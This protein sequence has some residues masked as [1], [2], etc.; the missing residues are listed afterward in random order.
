[1][2]ISNVCIMKSGQGSPRKLQPLS[3]TRR[4]WRTSTTSM[5][6]AQH[7]VQDHSQQR[8][9]RPNTL[10]FITLPRLPQS[11]QRLRKFPHHPSRLAGLCHRLLSAL[12]RIGL[13][14]PCLS[15]KSIKNQMDLLAPPYTHT[16]LTVAMAEDR[17]IYESKQLPP[18]LHKRAI[19]YRIR[20][21]ILP[22][23][24][25]HRTSRTSRY[26][27]PMHPNCFP[28]ERPHRSFLQHTQATIPHY[29]MPIKVPRMIILSKA[30]ML[31]LSGRGT[32]A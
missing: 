16:M 23:H 1:M 14:L 11:Q 30:K 17:A 9:Q 26:R 28:L 31:N 29:T 24:P 6:P 25:R 27:I 5:V 20:R 3:P 7:P 4:T 10:P 19:A 13:P 18:A 21:T 32:R 12:P 8:R 22:R 15:R 2:R